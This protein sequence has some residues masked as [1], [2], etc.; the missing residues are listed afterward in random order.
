MRG[1]KWGEKN[2]GQGKTGQNVNGLVITQSDRWP[3]RVGQIKNKVKV[4]SFPG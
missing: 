4:H 3:R 1:K 2:N